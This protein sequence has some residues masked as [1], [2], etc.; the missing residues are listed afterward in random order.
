[1]SIHKFLSKTLVAA[2]AAMAICTIVPALASATTA[3]PPLH[4]VPTPDTPAYLLDGGTGLPITT[5]Q[6]YSLSGTVTLHGT[7]AP[8]ITCDASLTVR[9]DPSGIADV[10]SPSAFT[11]CTTSVPGCNAALAPTLDWGGRYV[12][13]GNGDYR[14]RISPYLTITFSGT[15]PYGPI[16]YLG[17]ESP[18]M[19]V[20]GS[21]E[22]EATFDGLGAGHIYS[23]L[24]AYYLTGTLTESSPPAGWAFGI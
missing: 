16:T 10:T 15:C 8:D 19:T 4:T 7:S 1:M 20:N 2:A 18:I 11:N 5:S 13:D 6:S 3:P 21:G 12:L 17:E 23:A 24:T 14:H 22:V 9:A